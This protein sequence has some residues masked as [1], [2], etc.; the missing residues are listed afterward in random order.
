[1]FRKRLKRDLTA[2]CVGELKPVSGIEPKVDGGSQVP[3]AAVADQ[4]QITAILPTGVGHGIL[5]LLSLRCGLSTASLHRARGVGIVP[6]IGKKGVGAQIEWD[7][8]SVIV[9]P[10]RA[11]EIFA[12]IFH[13]GEVDRPHG[14]FIYMGQLQAVTPFMLPEV[15]VDPDATA[16]MEIIKPD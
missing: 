15:A 5:E 3:I 7:L 2:P 10:E 14:G 4:R 12:L 16:E 11:D 1:M 6:L 13:E 9:P 8:I